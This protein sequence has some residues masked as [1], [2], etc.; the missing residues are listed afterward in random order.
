VTKLD[1]GMLKE[2]HRE[3]DLLQY[4]AGRW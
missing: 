2:S 4:A 3:C 1:L